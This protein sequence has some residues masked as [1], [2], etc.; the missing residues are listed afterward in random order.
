MHTRL[1]S[2][3]QTTKPVIYYGIQTVIQTRSSWLQTVFSDNSNWEIGFNSWQLGR[4]KILFVQSR[5]GGIFFF[6]IQGFWQKRHLPTKLPK[7]IFSKLRGWGAKDIIRI[8]YT[9]S[10]SQQISL[11]GEVHG[12]RW[13]R[14]QNMTF[15]FSNLVFLLH[16]LFQKTIK[17]ESTCDRS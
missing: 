11:N 10:P 17:M 8:I 9:L 15:L 2:N 1:C 3:L 12:E 4:S 6:S 16:V 13:F 7:K 14:Q 5:G